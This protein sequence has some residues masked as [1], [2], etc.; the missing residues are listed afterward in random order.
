MISHCA[1]LYFSQL[2]KQHTVV[3]N[4]NGYQFQTLLVIGS[5]AFLIFQMGVSRQH[6]KFDGHDGGFNHATALR[7]AAGATGIKRSTP[8]GHGNRTQNNGS[9]AVDEILMDNAMQRE[10]TTV[11]NNNAP[12]S[13]SP[14]VLLYITTHMSDQHILH[15][16]SCW[17][18]ALQ[19]SLQ[20]CSTPLMSWFTTP[21]LLLKNRT[22][23]VA[24]RYLR[25]IYYREHSRSRN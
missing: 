6:N 12:S 2:L 22:V 9:I 15:L 23:H 19:N 4:M 14:K 13:R 3:H 11:E 25:S 17:P 18:P 7:A 21:L 8:S 1:L 10:F 20:Y 24:T 5:V 16:Q